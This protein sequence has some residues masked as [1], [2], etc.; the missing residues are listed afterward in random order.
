MMRHLDKPNRRNK[1]TKQSSEARPLLGI[2]MGDPAGIGPEVIAKALA[3]AK[4]RRLC[5]PLVI[6]S[7]PVMQQTV[8][9]LKLKMNVIRVEG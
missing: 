3:G 4:V 8:K 2:T 7:L 5:R 1:P 9:S 6:G